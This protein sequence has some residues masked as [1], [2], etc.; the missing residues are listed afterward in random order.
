MDNGLIYDREIQQEY[1]KLILEHQIVLGYI[2]KNKRVLE[3]GCHT[4][5]FSY[6]IKKSNNLVIGIDIYEP[7]IE[8]ATPFLNKGIVGNIENDE[9][10]DIL[11]NEKFDV[12]VFMHVLEHLVD[13]QKV[14]E[15]AKRILS[16]EGSI[17]IALPNISNL[18]SR[19]NILKGDFTYTPSGLMDVTHLRF[20]NYVTAVKMINN[21]GYQVDEYKGCGIAEILWV[22]NLPLIWRLNKH[23]NRFVRFILGKKPNLWDM[24]LIFSISKNKN[25]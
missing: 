1:D 5:Y 21:S 15:R 17:V 24:V 6:W 8:K 18:H 22:P 20:F 2:G 9:V 23:I 11:A 3:I 14:L 16:E 7:A 12:I 19:V 25:E 13:P 4:G 10:W